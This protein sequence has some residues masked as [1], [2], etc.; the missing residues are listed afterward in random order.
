MQIVQHDTTITSSSEILSTPKKKKIRYPGDISNDLLEQMTPTT[1]RKS[2]RLLR[3][4]CQKKDHK[5]KRLQSIQNR[6]KKKIESLQ[7]LLLDL[8]KNNLLS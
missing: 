5:I 3:E 7:A 2:V 8:K 1:L 6:Q 4:T